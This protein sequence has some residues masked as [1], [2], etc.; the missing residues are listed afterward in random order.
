MISTYRFIRDIVN[1]H[2]IP[3]AFRD[4]AVI[5]VIPVANPKGFDANTYG[6]P[7]GVSINKNFDWNWQEGKT[8]A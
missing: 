3:K 8:N 1:G 4:G 7:N 5:H 6:K 2:N